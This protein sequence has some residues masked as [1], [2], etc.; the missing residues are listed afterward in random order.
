MKLEH[1]RQEVASLTQF[2]IRLGRYGLF[3]MILIAFSLA[4][5]VSGYH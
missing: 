1:H 3:S 4:I 5:G 2:F